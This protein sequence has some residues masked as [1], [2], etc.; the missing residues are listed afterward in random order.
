MNDKSKRKIKGV[1]VVEIQIK[2]FN[3]LQM[4][5]LVRLKMYTR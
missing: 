5:A 2:R 3:Y 4:T 1:S